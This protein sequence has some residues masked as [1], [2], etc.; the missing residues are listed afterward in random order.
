[1]NRPLGDVNGPRIVTEDDTPREWTV[2]FSRTVANCVCPP[3]ATE[4][5]CDEPFALQAVTVSAHSAK[6]AIWIA[7]QNLSSEGWRCG[8]EPVD[9]PLYDDLD[10]AQIEVAGD[11]R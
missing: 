8:T 9:R 6:E 5:N 3:D 7:S 4:C 1:M 11:H 10:V 2:T